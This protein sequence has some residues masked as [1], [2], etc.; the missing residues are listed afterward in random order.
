M[1]LG[2]AD[3]KSSRSELLWNPWLSVTQSA[4][5]SGTRLQLPKRNNAL[6]SEPC[7]VLRVDDA[8]DQD[9]Q[10]DNRWAHDNDHNEYIAAITRFYHPVAQA[11]D[12]SDAD[13]KLDTH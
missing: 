7:F 13:V 12:H 11:S 9:S 8:V 2:N 6:A 5:A 10:Q 3:W 1:E 4:A